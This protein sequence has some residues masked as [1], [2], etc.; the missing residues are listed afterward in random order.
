M[1]DIFGEDR[2]MF[3]SDWPVS[4]TGNADFKDVFK[5]AEDLVDYC[6]LS[7]EAKE[8]FFRHNAIKFY[9]LKIE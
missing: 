1:F 8:K 4:L 6:G 3:G 7:P 2:C 9:N 5:L